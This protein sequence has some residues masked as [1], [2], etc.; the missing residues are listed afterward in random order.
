MV[1]DTLADMLTRI[2]N[3]T[4]IGKKIVIMPYAKMCEAVAR[5][6]LAENYLKAVKVE[7]EGKDKKLVLTP[8]YVKGISA[9]AHVRRI[10]KPGVR[11]YSPVTELRS[12]LSG[13]GISILSTSKGIMSDRGAKKARLGG[14]VLLELW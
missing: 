8:M 2:K 14:E 11:I 6:M 1:T 7:G 3:A 13:M 9:I 12:V 4:M 5:V 10:S